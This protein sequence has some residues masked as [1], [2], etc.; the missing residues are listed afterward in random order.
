[1]KLFFD[2][3]PIVCFFICYK[4]F[5]LMLATKV[6]I[7]ISLL[8][9]LLTRIIS[10]KLQQMTL[11]SFLTVTLL[12][13]ATLI[14]DNEIF[15][16]WKPT[17]V[18]WLLSLGFLLT[19]YLD[20]TLAQ[21]IGEKAIELPVK[22]WRLLNLSWCLFFL[23]MGALNLYVVYNFATSVWVNFKLFGTLALT[24]IFVIAQSI[25]MTK[26]AAISQNKLE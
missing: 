9:V 5:G 6:T 16:K 4:F 24:V 22:N 18:Y 7:G 2:I 20:K 23:F 13:G 21:R 15:I 19:H 3:F 1:M 17:V 14:F 26:H 25:Y 12:G 10:G 11:V 8:Q